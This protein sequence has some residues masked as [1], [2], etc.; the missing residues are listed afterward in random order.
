MI[1]CAFHL[2]DFGAAG[3]KCCSKLFDYV[4][5]ALKQRM[6]GAGRGSEGQ[7]GKRKAK[8]SVTRQTKRVLSA[9][10]AKLVGQSHAAGRQSGNHNGVS[11]VPSTSPPPLPPSP[12]L[13]AKCTKLQHAV[14][15]SRANTNRGQAQAKKSTGHAIYSNGPKTGPTETRKEGKRA[16]TA[17]EA[18]EESRTKGID[19][20]ID[21]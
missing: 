6:V 15:L 16:C 8:M 9:C 21:G 2:P 18:G 19:M 5:I 17:M 10:R 1:V 4:K 12:C 11:G 13:G 7:R 20:Q 14:C 3:S